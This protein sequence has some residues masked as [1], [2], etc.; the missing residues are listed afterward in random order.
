MSAVQKVL[1]K[2]FGSRNER[3]LKR[4]TRIVQQINAKEADIQKLTDAQLAAR[5]QEIPHGLDELLRRRGWWN[6]LAAGEPLL[7]DGTS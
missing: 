5:T 1:T 6:E 7:V 2:I 4:Y 3:L